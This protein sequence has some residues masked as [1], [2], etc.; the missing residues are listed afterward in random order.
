M[1]SLLIGG[2]P[3]NPARNLQKPTRDPDPVHGTNQ[4]NRAKRI[5]KQLVWSCAFLP[6]KALK[7]KKESKSPFKS[8]R[9]FEQIESRKFA[10]PLTNVECTKTLFQTAELK[11]QI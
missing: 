3:N 6:A 5:G 4:P 7:R 1:R 11:N 9:Y 2:P 10:V 8:L